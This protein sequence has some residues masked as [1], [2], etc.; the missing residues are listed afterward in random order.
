MGMIKIQ[1]FG[2]FPQEEKTFSA[3]QHGHADAV[4]QAI[5]YLIEKLTWAT[6]RDHKL[7]EQ[8][9]SPTYGFNRNQLPPPVTGSRW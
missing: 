6:G 1:M 9:E 2:S 4:T 7:H 3:M 8:G 5:A